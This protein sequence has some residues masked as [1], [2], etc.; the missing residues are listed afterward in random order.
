MRKYGYIGRKFF[1]SKMWAGAASSPFL[2][3]HLKSLNDFPPRQTA[4]SLSMK[5]AVEAAMKKIEST[6]GG[7]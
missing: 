6:S 7:K 3:A 5:K 2:A 1:A 4:E